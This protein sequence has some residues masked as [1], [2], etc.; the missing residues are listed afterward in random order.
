MSGS[1][2][3]WNGRGVILTH[4]KLGHGRRLHVTQF[5]HSG[6]RHE[7]SRD[8]VRIVVCASS[9]DA[10]PPSLVASPSIH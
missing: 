7:Y 6:E 5:R 9:D 1:A 4:V 10:L 8:A 2:V 3:R